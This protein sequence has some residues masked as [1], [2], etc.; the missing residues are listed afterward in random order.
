M[1]RSSARRSIATRGTGFGAVLCAVHGMI[2]AGCGDASM[3]VT[4]S[5]V[6]AIVSDGGGG[7]A[8]LHTGAGTSIYRRNSIVPLRDTLDGSAMRLVVQVLGLS[9]VEILEEQPTGDFTAAAVPAPPIDAGTARIP[10]GLAASDVTGDGIED[11]LVMD[12]VGNWLA[13]G[14]VDGTF[15]ATDVDPRMRS[16]LATPELAFLSPGDGGDVLVGSL[17]GSFEVETRAPGAAWAEP[18]NVAVPWPW[19]DTTVSPQFVAIEPVG[20][21]SQ[22]VV[23]GAA[24]LNLF[25]MSRGVHGSI[26]NLGALTQAAVF[27]PYVAPF[28]AFDHL[29]MLSLA[30]CDASAVGVGVFANNPAGVPRQLERL[31]LS[32]TTYTIREI[33]TPFDVI[34]VGVVDGP[35]AD[36]IVGVIGEQGS[37]SVFAAYRVSD[38]DTWTPLGTVPTDFAWRSPSPEVPKTDGVQMFGVQTMAPAADANQYRFLHYDG[39]DVRV[40]DIEVTNAQ[41][42]I[43]S[44]SFKKMSIHGERKD[45]AF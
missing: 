3:G 2:V 21:D 45:L 10:I 39:Y 8:A 19:I 14:V 13:R 24:R 25:D 7:Q 40:W 12:T 18:V 17:I 35:D 20:G 27:A 33:S 37:S 44:F 11:I 23:A 16:F 9:D 4:D 1:G 43:A 42:P 31:A 36:A 5:A 38:C 26:T 28:D 15:A 30:G 32:S 22:L 6:P 34:S 29:Q 41:P